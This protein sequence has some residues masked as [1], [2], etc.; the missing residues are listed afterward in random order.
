M[1]NAHRHVRRVRPHAGLLVESLDARLLLSGGAAPAAALVH[2]QPAIDAHHDHRIS[3]REVLKDPPRS[4]PL[5]FDRALR[6]LYREYEGSGGLT[7]VK[8][9]PPVTGLMVSGSRVAVVIKVAYP[10]ALGGFYLR[11][12]RADG[13]NVFGT[14]R[15]EGLAEG[16]VPIAN[17]PDITPLVAHVWPYYEASP[18]SKAVK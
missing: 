5:C 4:L 10:P 15:A 6:L 16:T 2:D 12:L 8:T 18:S 1:L 7:L 11:D 3:P 17:L 13:L 14:T 9:S